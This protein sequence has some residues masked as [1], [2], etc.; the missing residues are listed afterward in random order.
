MMINK[1]VGGK[2]GLTAAGFFIIEK[3]FLF[4]VF[5]SLLGYFLV[6]QSFK[7]TTTEDCD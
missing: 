5:T 1:L 4:S 3:P 2:I 7:T 6:L